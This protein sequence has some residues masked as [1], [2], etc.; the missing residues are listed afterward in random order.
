[1]PTQSPVA[2]ALAT[3]G[4]PHQIFEHPAP[5]ETLEQAAFERGQRPEQVVRS[6][7]FRAPQQEYILVM[8][9]G[10]QQID[11][12]ILR[13]YLGISRVTL[14]APHEVLLITGYMIGTVAPFGLTSPIRILVDQ[15]VIEQDEVSMGSGIPNV[16]V[17]IKT[18]ILLKALE[19]PEIAN[20]T[21]SRR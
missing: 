10:S 15:S 12:K 13:K 21:A 7:L 16:A 20:L 1:M 9:A 2:L 8:V 14:A 17:I 5:V 18:E 4:F 11:W 6:I 3:G 19:R